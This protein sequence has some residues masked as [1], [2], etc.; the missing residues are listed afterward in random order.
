LKKKLGRSQAGTVLLS[1]ERRSTM[2]NYNYYCIISNYMHE[3]KYAR[4]DLANV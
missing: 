4:P 2:D 1:T 3:Q